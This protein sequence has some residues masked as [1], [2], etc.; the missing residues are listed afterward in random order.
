[1]LLRHSSGRVRCKRLPQSRCRQCCAGLY[2]VYLEAGAEPQLVTESPSLSLHTTQ[3]LQSRVA[4]CRPVT[5]K[6]VLGL[7]SPCNYQTLS[8]ARSGKVDAYPLG[9][10]GARI[11]R[12]HLAIVTHTLPV[13]HACW[14]HRAVLLSTC[15]H[16]AQPCCHSNCP[17]N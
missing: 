10:Y 16:T 3:T 2:G 8:S 4:G 5:N 15:C 13:H 6:D 7:P 9:D 1:M 17:V 12:E 14:V 11:A